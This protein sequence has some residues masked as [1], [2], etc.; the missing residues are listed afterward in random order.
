MS[1][2]ASEFFKS[3]ANQVYMQLNA[4]L[5]KSIF[6]KTQIK[7]VFE[8]RRVAFYSYDFIK[9]M[10]NDI[11]IK[12]LMVCSLEPNY[13]RDMLSSSRIEVDKYTKKK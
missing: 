13:I 2:K 4:Y 8:R 3:K 5:L 10:D 12:E 7:L 11:T 9:L 1:S 6:H